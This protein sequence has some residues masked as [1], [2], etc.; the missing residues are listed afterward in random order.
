MELNAYSTTKNR[1]LILE[2]VLAA[3]EVAFA[4]CLFYYWFSSIHYQAIQFHNYG[5]NL[6]WW[7]WVI[8]IQAMCFLIMTCLIA[9]V[10]LFLNKKTGWLLSVSLWIAK[11]CIDVPAILYGGKLGTSNFYIILIGLLM[12]ALVC[13]LFSRPIRTKYKVV[14]WDTLIVFCMVVVIDIDAHWRYL[15]KL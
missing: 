11:L 13:A 3:M 5:Y 7:Q 4:I 8:W 15:L 2:K 14:K 9:G 1:F 10:L 12:A 6:K